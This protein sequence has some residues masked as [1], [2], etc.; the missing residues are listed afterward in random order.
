[1]D[2]NEI[3]NGFRKLADSIRSI[4]ADFGLREHSATLVWHDF[5]GDSLGEG[6]EVQTAHP[7]L[8]NG[9]NPKVR[10]PSQKEIALGLMSK[11]QCT[12]GPFTPE[13]DTGG[14]DRDLLNGSI[15]P[16]GAPMPVGSLLLVK[17]QGPQC[18][19]GILHRIANCNVDRALRVTLTCDP[20]G[21]DGSANLT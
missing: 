13:Y 20:V 6:L 15:M 7:I 2:A 8:V 4:P 18:P 1:M 19:D 14:I 9:A 5:S 10:F 16:S 11:G 21:P 17:V 12:V 3:R